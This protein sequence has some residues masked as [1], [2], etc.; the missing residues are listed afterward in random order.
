MKDNVDNTSAYYGPDACDLGE[1]TALIGQATRCAQVPQAAAIEKNIPIY[2]M[3]HLR[4]ALD[5]D[6]TRRGI[7]AEW[8]WVLRSGAGVVALKGA[9]ADTTV[10]DEAT[11]EAGSWGRGRSLCSVGSERSDMERAAKALRSIA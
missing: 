9:Y 1:F 5:D 2:D 4:P 6:R 10:L 8:A 3:A 11:R 7:M